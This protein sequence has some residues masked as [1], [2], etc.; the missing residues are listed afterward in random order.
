MFHITSTSNVGSL[1]EATEGKFEM[2]T[3]RLPMADGVER[4]GVVIGGAS[5][6]IA[7]G[8]PMDEFEAARDIVLYMTNTENMVS[9]HKLTGYYRVR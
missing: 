9:W 3:G 6:W 7:D 5:I 4:N 8:H 2:G 1:C